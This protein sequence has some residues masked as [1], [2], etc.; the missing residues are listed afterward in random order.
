MKWLAI[1]LLLVLGA[2]SDSQRNQKQQLFRNT[3]KQLSVNHILILDTLGNA[4]ADAEIRIG[5]FTNPKAFSIITKTN[6]NGEFEIPADWQIPE[7]LSILSPEHVRTSYIN[8]EANS[9]ILYIEPRQTEEMQVIGDTIDYGNLRLDG[10]IDFSLVIPMQSKH[11]LM[12]FR[13]DKYMHSEKEEMRFPLGQSLNINANISF[14]DQRERYSFV[15]LRFNKPEYRFP[16][17]QNGEFAFVANRGRFELDQLI[18]RYR[19]TNDI[20][21]VFN[22]LEFNS[23]GMASLQGG[24]RQDISVNQITYLGE[25]EFE[26]LLTMNERMHFISLLHPK[27]ELYYP[28]DI[29]LLNPGERVKL[30]YDLNASSTKVMEILAQ[31]TEILDSVVLEKAKSVVW[32]DLLKRE[33][34]SFLATPAVPVDSASDIRSEAPP[35]IDGLNAYATHFQLYDVEINREQGNY[36]E[37]PN[38]KWNIYV[39]A[40]ENRVILPKHNLDS[41]DI[42]HTKMWEV[43]YIAGKDTQTLNYGPLSIH[44]ATHLAKNAQQP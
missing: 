8:L 22:L 13:L 29:K 10:Y 6:A 4:V 40:W 1:A 28:S 24:T 18:D 35:L 12:N 41:I 43:L 5:D 30:V 17:Y 16:I 44:R 39:P 9:Q 27:D 14:P 37:K 26:S 2:C 21:S 34:P 20:F 11:N 15:T 42:V 3:N 32:Q 31:P 25:A 7:N 38:P 36:F 33:N 19:Q 23:A